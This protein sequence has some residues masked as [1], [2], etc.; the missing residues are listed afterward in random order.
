MKNNLIINTLTLAMLAILLVA[1]GGEEEA[2]PTLAPT[3]GSEVQSDDSSDADADTVESEESS[4]EDTETESEP[5]ASNEENAETDSD[6]T[7]NTAS[8]S[9]AGSEVLTVDIDYSRANNVGESGTASLS[10]NAPDGWSISE[11]SIVRPEVYTFLSLTQLADSPVSYD[12]QARALPDFETTHDINGVTVY[13][14]RNE[15]SGL[16]SFRRGFGDSEL[17]VTAFAYGDDDTV[18]LDFV[19]D[20]VQFIGNADVTTGDLPELDPITIELS[21]DFTAFVSGAVEGSMVSAFGVDLCSDTTT[22]ISYTNL[23]NSRDNEVVGDVSFT[24]NAPEVGEY[25]YDRENFDIPPASMSAYAQPFDEGEDY[26]NTITYTLTLDTIAT[27]PGEAFSGSYTIT[28]SQLNDLDPETTNTTTIT[29]TF[30]H[31]MD[32]LCS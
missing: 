5:A 31:I 16:P 12:E 17:I 13:E 9:V 15:R 28:L 22:R 10:T 3:V 19:D 24:F 32:E 11:Q 4:E 7:E 23:F 2:L 8:Q 21:D 14:Y 29:G 26:T 27:A 18:V 25:I 1:C 30:T 20:M 6:T